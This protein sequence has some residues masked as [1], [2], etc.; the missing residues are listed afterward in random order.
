MNGFLRPLPVQ[1]ESH[2]SLRG[3]RPPG[4]QPRHARTHTSD[5]C[6]PWPRWPPATAGLPLRAPPVLHGTRP[7]RKSP[8]PLPPDHEGPKGALRPRTPS[9]HRPERIGPG[10]GNE[11]STP[12]GKGPQRWGRPAPGHSHSSPGRPLTAAVAPRLRRAQYG[13]SPGQGPGR[14]RTARNG[15]DL[16][17]T[18]FSPVTPA[19]A[20][21]PG[22]GSG[23]ELPSMF[24]RAHP[25]P[26][27]AARPPGS[28]GP[29][30]RTSA[31]AEPVG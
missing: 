9:L 23:F 31:N 14:P 19:P 27:S 1:K 6:C 16:P 26:R 11:V 10:S 29:R 22:K 18:V 30:A 12:R 20:T 28:P 21:T 4:P 17:P 25:A 13:C 5:L 7:A 24:P 8:E 3:T 2:A 15:L